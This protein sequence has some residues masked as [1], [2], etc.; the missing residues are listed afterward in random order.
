MKKSKGKRDLDTCLSPTG[1]SPADS[2]TKA[3]K[4]QEEK[5]LILWT[6]PVFNQGSYHCK[7][8]VFFWPSAPNPDRLCQSSYSCRQLGCWCPRL[9][10]TE[11]KLVVFV[12]T[13]ILSGL[14][15]LRTVRL[16]KIFPV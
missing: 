4:V 6:L 10:V 5:L 11:N 8:L 1:S 13:S 3:W 7:A 9:K 12:Y 15:E 2:T 16:S 14:D